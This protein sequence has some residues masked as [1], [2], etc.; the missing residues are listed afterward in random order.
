MAKDTSIYYQKRYISFIFKSYFRENLVNYFN[1]LDP[2]NEYFAKRRCEEVPFQL[3]QS[4]QWTQL[5]NFLVDISN[6]KLMLGEDMKIDLYRYWRDTAQKVP[7]I[8]KLLLQGL[9]NFTQSNKSLSTIELELQAGEF[10]QDIA[11]YDSAGKRAL[12]L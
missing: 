2:K 4:L 5:G 1:G 9:K 6:F 7:N 12:S 3:Y 10:L 11:A 8:E